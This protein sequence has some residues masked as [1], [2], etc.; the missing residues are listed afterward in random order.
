MISNQPAKTDNGFLERSS[1]LVMGVGGAGVFCVAKLVENPMREVDCIV[2]DVD[3][4]N[5]EPIKECEK[6]LLAPNIAHGIGTGRRRGVG[7]RVAL[8]EEERLKE[9]L[10]GREILFLVIGLAGGLGAGMAPRILALAADLG[11]F[12]VVLGIA[13]FEMEGCSLDAKGTLDDVL[14]EANL[15]FVISNQQ[16]ASQIMKEE[17]AI[18]TKIFDLVNQQIVQLIH[19]FCA[20]LYLPSMISLDLGLLWKNFGRGDS[21]TPICFA[22]ASAEGVNRIELLWEKLASHPWIKEQNAISLA[23]HFLLFIR[24]ENDLNYKEVEM[25]KEYLACANPAAK[26]IMGVSLQNQ[27]LNGKISAILICTFSE[28]K[29]Q[30]EERIT[31]HRSLYKNGILPGVLGEDEEKIKQPPMGQNPAPPELPNLFEEGV[32]EVRKTLTKRR[33]SKS[34]QDPNQ[35]ILDLQGER[36]LKDGS[37][38]LPGERFRDCSRTFFYKKGRSICLDVPTYQ[39]VGY[40]I[41]NIGAER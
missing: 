41:K 38:V 27:G 28:A 39:R 35:G 40:K 29:K 30:T 8:A 3:S 36:F 11:V 10:M 18:F 20:G 13:P 2:L 25:L 32:K 12:T 37:G 5:L 15:V 1:A 19:G 33:T 23:R 9:L 17:D 22:T 21:F 26:L 7:V 34:V 14:P 16:L 31:S 6:L 24:G 4:R